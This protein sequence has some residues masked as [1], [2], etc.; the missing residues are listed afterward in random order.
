[1]LGMLA[2]VAITMA[3]ADETQ[4]ARH[5]EVEAAF[6]MIEAAETAMYEAEVYADAEI[7]FA[8]VLEEA[9]LDGSTLARDEMRARTGDALAATF[10]H[11]R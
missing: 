9:G 5:V 8:S 1:M 3:G 7:D 11:N 10:A 2:L 6:A 4:C